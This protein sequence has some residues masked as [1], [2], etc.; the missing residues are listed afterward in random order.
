[1]ALASIN[2]AH[3]DEREADHAAL[4]EIMKIATEALN[5]KNLELLKPVLSSKRF[6]IT[7]VDNQ[8]FESLEDFSNYWKELFE[9]EGAR[10][11]RIAVDPTADRKTEFLADSVGVVEG[12]STE[13]YHFTDG[14]VISMQT[15]WSAVTTREGDDWKLASVH[16]SANLLDNPLLD[17]AKKKITQYVIAAAIAGLLL[18][19]ILMR[20]FRGQKTAG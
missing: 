20:V 17:A 10:L 9:G 8:K 5:T 13:T 14:D 16:F 11:V 4:R 18:G 1:M 3:A 12:V 15:R 2:A 19:L 7:T 6:T